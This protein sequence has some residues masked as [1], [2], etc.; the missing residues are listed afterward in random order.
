LEFAGVRN[1]LLELAFD[2]RVADVFVL[3]DA[4]GVNGEGVGTAR[5]A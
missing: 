1:E 3:E 2:R 5:R 4:V